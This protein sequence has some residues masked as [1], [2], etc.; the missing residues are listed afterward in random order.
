MN[1]SAMA[2]ETAPVDARLA[3]RLHPACS[4]LLQRAETYIALHPCT[5]HVPRSGR[6]CAVASHPLLL[7]KAPCAKT[8]VSETARAA[9][10]AMGLELL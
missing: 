2:Y 3:F 4:R 7:M 10:W 5:L 1:G 9:S 8:W 6:R